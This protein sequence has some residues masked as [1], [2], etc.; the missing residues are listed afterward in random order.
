M[1]CHGQS[2]ENL[3]GLNF[4]LVRCSKVH[5]SPFETC[6]PYVDYFFYKRLFL[7]T[8]TGCSIVL[9][10]GSSDSKNGVLWPAS[11]EFYVLCFKY[12][13]CF[14]TETKKFRS[15]RM[16]FTCSTVALK[17]TYGTFPCLLWSPLLDFTMAHFCI[18][19][20]KIW[21]YFRFV[22]IRFY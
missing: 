22:F 1:S 17:V 13:F 8:H 5:P 20:Q 19:H 9:E 18:F 2:L 15:L 4:K 3:K 6:Q 10:K 16:A 7:I 12:L 14:M 21:I 11:F